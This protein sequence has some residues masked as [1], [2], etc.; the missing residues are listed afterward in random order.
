MTDD[1]FSDDLRRDPL[2]LSEARLAKNEK[3][4]GCPVTWLLRV[5]PAVKS[6]KQ[7]VAAIYLWRRH[8]VCGHRNTFDVPNGEL[9]NWGIS[10]HIKYRTLVQLRT[11]GILTMKQIGKETFSVTILPEKQK[12][13]RI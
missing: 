8:V 1:L 9:K 4:I 10:R 6:K 5:L 2:S 3:F 12:K 7:L 11:A 13:K